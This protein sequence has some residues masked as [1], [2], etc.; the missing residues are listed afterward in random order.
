M[1]EAKVVGFIPKEHL[2]AMALYEVTWKRRKVLR[3]EAKRETRQYK[4][5]KEEGYFPFKGALGNL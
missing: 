2:E 3:R 1:S 4:K 5:H